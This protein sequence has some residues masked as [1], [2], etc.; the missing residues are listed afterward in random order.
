MF[1]RILSSC[2]S[3]AAL[4]L[5]V[6]CAGSEPEL[7]FDAEWRQALETLPPEILN[8]PQLAAVPAP[9]VRS[10]TFAHSYAKQDREYAEEISILESSGGLAVTDTK[11]SDYWLM[12]KGE[13][14]G[15]SDYVS[16]LSSAQTKLTAYGGI[17]DLIEFNT[18]ELNGTRRDGLSFIQ[19][20]KTVSGSL[21][22]L[23][24][25]NT[26]QL[27]AELV[28][29]GTEN[30]SD[31]TQTKVTPI[32]YTFRVEKAFPASV[33]HPN[34]SGTAW[35]ITKDD[36]D[37]RLLVEDFG[38]A[39][40]LPGEL[41][42]FDDGQ[43]RV[44][45]SYASIARGHAEAGLASN[46]R[47][48]AAMAGALMQLGQASAGLAA[49]LAAPGGGTSAPSLPSYPGVSGG[50]L[51]Q[52]FATTPTIGGGLPAGPMPP[53]TGLALN[54]QIFQQRCVDV[55]P[56]DAAEAQACQALA[57]SLGRSYTPPSS[58]P[59]MVGGY[60]E[61]PPACSAGRRRRGCR[62]STNR[63][64]SSAAQAARRPTPRT[65]RHAKGWRRA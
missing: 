13:G 31:P 6:A 45:P 18:E 36:G 14:I 58:G 1:F 48:A 37:R 15:G 46:E 54:E 61:N 3:V 59:S 28:Q 55:T 50:R 11:G 26:M 39:I 29:K 17:V 8:D 19:N 35:R 33:L 57:Q 62:I 2:L 4:S 9:A 47:Q 56:R 12:N 10:M 60:G 52:T 32:S 30:P 42:G 44:G 51:P 23:E 25:G 38:Y 63:S 65:L 21:F 5:V 22:P 20:V 34:L 24:V 27:S 41:V 7:N 43:R 16:Y 64:L 49:T 53:S 40:S